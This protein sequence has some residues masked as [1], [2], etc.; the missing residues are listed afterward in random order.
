MRADPR[1]PLGPPQRRSPAAAAAVPAAMPAPATAAGALSDVAPPLYLGEREVAMIAEL[2]QRALA[3]PLWA[4]ELDRR[5]EEARHGWPMPLDP[6]FLVDL[7]IGYR[8]L[9][10]VEDAL[11]SRWQHL[12][13]INGR[14]PSHPAPEP[15]M[16]RLLAAFGFAGKLSDTP[17]WFSTVSG[18]GRVI[19]AIEEIARPPGAPAG[20][21]TPPAPPEFDPDQVGPDQVD[22]ELVDEEEAGEEVAG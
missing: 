10:V 22:P 2:R 9:F 17:L 16:A 8:A 13:V 4:G 7:P 5:L 21:P 6:E 20:G 18:G 15:V 12:A 1:L 3:R 11:R 14:R 19:N